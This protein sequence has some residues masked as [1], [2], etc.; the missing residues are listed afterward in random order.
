MDLAI[1]VI[2]GGSFK[3][4][5]DSLVNDMLMP[6]IG[7][8]TGNVDLSALSVHLRSVELKYGL[9]LNAVINFLIIAFVIF[10]TIKIMAK[11]RLKQT[12]KEGES[13]PEDIAL[14]RQIRDSL[15]KD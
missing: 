13:T 6:V 1:G 12:E 9:F 8:L 7:G 3:A 2:I 15:K 4:I 5:V 11:A 10:T 14:L